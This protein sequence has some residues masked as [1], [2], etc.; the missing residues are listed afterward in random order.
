MCFFSSLNTKINSTINREWCRDVTLWETFVVRVC[1]AL[2]PMVLFC[3]DYYMLIESRWN[4]D[5][6]WIFNT[7]SV[8]IRVC[9]CLFGVCLFVDLKPKSTY[10]HIHSVC[11]HISLVWLINALIWKLNGLFVKCASQSEIGREKT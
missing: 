7:F 4:G 2:H 9:V 3:D 8:S 11:I 10:R 1:C 5:N 6:Y